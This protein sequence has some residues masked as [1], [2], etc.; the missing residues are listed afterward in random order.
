MQILQSY[1]EICSSWHSFCQF[2]SAIYDSFVAEWCPFV[3]LR[4]GGEQCN[5][6]CFCQFYT[7]IC[8]FYMVSKRPWIPKL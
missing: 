5:I 4:C 2:Q 6:A 1:P 7:F 8:Q 3:T